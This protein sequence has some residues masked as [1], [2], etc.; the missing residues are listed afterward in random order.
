MRTFVIALQSGCLRA[1]VHG[2]YGEVDLRDGPLVLQIAQGGI[3][4]GL[5]GNG[6]GGHGGG[7]EDEHWPGDGMRNEMG[8]REGRSQKERV[9]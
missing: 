8:R 6:R 4:L 9:K 2:M 7:R 5:T 3:S 1:I